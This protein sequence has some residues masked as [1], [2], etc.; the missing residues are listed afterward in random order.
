MKKLLLLVMPLALLSACGTVSDN[1]NSDDYVFADYDYDVNDYVKLSKYKGLTLEL[2]DD[3]EITDAD[4]KANIESQLE[5]FPYYKKIKKT[6]VEDG[7]YLNITYTGYINNE[8]VE[9]ASG[10]DVDMQVGA[11]E[12]DYFTKDNAFE[13]GLIGKKVGDKIQ[14]KLTFSDDYVDSDL[15]GQNVTFKI[16]I[17]QI[18]EQ[19]FY[20]Y[21]D[22]TD[23]IVEEI[24]SYDSLDE[25]FEYEKDELVEN[26]NTT[27]ESDTKDGILNLLLENNEVE[28]PEELKE[29]RVEE[30]IQQYEQMCKENDTTLSDYL[31]LYYGITEDEFR[32]NIED[33]MSETLM[34]EFVLQAIADKENITYDKTGFDEYVDSIVDEYGYEDKDEVIDTYGENYIKRDYLLFEKT[35]N[36]IKDNTKITYGK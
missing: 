29:Q 16:K 26:A 19:K 11:A 27:K 9:A 33:F 10:E 6:T 12:Y 28:Y 17:N 22:L 24:F 36:F 3:Y 31:D 5:S 23:D 14:L 20:T 21:D 35:Y 30:Y 25:Y 2:E 15:A 8:E 13:K 7:D 18:E 1:T 4:V 34:Q 32:E